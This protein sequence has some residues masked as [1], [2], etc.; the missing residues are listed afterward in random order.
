MTE[1]QQHISVHMISL[2][3]AN[4]G[5][6]EVR[7]LNPQ[8]GTKDWDE[9]KYVK[10]QLIALDLIE[11]KNKKLTLCLTPKGW[12]F[13]S[14]EDIEVDKQSSKSGLIKNKAKNLIVEL[15]KL[16]DPL[17]NK[18]L[19][20]IHGRI[21]ILI[22]ND[23]LLSQKYNSKITKMN[24][25]FKPAKDI[26]IFGRVI[27]EGYQWNQTIKELK[28]ILIYIMD[29][30][31]ML[32][33]PIAQKKETLISKN[34][35]F[36]ASLQVIRLIEQA[37]NN[38]KLVDNYV[39]NETLKLLSGKKQHVMVKIL[40]KKKSNSEQF[41]FMIDRYNKQYHKLEIRTSEKIHD[42]FL[43]IDDSMYYNFGAS[44]KDIGGTYS[45][46]SQINDKPVQKGIADMFNEE[47][48]E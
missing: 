29:E 16:N 20:G 40:T 32:D 2:L 13:E 38:I 35:Q 18:E 9:E 1:R 25:R 33:Q 15:N 30:M 4:D 45:M 42:R 23:P 26:S 12:N 8:L 28:N 43:I 24:L 22:E 19:E 5:Y 47:W 3:K 6:M 11:Y 10:D 46:F 27:S 21:K 44:L 37:K 31:D 36:D 34:N 41:Q 7:E 14:F 48:G 39:N 17:Q